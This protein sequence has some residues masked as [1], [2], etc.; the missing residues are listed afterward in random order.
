MLPEPAS[1]AGVRDMDRGGGE[2]II[3]KAIIIILVKRQNY[4]YRS[5]IIKKAG[6]RGGKGKSCSSQSGVN[7]E[8]KGRGHSHYITRIDRGRAGWGRESSVCCRRR[9]LR[10]FFP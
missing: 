10:Y 2:G 8:R 6:D 5:V 1:N 3:M 7:R 4:N 9:F